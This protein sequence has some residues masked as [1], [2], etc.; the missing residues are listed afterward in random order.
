M[1]RG[2]VWPRTEYTL[3]ISREGEVGLSAS[4]PGELSPTET[5]RMPLSSPLYP[6]NFT[7]RAT[8]TRIH[9][10]FDDQF[11]GVVLHNYKGV[12]AQERW[13]TAES[14][15]GVSCVSPP[16]VNLFWVGV[17]QTTH[18]ARPGPPAAVLCSR[19]LVKLRD[20]QWHALWG[21]KTFALRWHCTA[22]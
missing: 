22:Y 1:V 7:A 19:L 14:G 17:Q 15:L 13:S 6:Q 9:R 18:R 16:L 21:I 10:L 11:I 12:D 5:T 3:T 20:A 2:A 4:A 8:S